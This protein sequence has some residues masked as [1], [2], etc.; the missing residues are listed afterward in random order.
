MQYHSQTLVPFFLGRTLV[1]MNGEM[2]FL[3]FSA[4]IDGKTTGAPVV[5]HVCGVDIVEIK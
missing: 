2:C 1:F 3:M 5:V 4:A